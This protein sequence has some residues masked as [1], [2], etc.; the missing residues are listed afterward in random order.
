MQDGLIPLQTRCTAS[1]MTAMLTNFAEAAMSNFAQLVARRWAP[2]LTS[3][4]LCAFATR[5]TRNVSS[6]FPEAYIPVAGCADPSTRCEPGAWFGMV[7]ALHAPHV[8]ICVGF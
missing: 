2:I 8:P 5:P 3:T 4:S 1:D 7:C 6:P